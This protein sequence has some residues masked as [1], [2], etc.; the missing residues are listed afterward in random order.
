[1]IPARADLAALDPGRR[2]LLRR[3]LEERGIDPASLPIPPRP[4]PAAPAPL[5]H[6][7]ERLW[8]L[9]RLEPGSA[10]VEC[11]AADLDGDLGADEPGAL[12]PAAL[13]AA[14]AALA[15]RHEA[16]RTVFEESVFEEAVSEETGAG[17][18]QRVLPPPP[19]RLPLADLSALPPPA[20]AAEAAR[21]EAAE[22]RRPFDLERGP[23]MRAHL[24]RLGGGRH[25]LLLGFH[26]IVCDARALSL[27]AGELGELYAAARDRRPARLAPPPLQYADYAVWQREWLGDAWFERRLETRRRGLAGAPTVLDLPADRP[28]SADRRGRGA[29]LRWRLP[30]AV[31]GRAAALA[32]DAG[33]TPFMVLLAALAVVLGRAAGQRDLLI[34]TP[35]A[36]RPRPE[37]EGVVGF[38]VNTLVLRA[39]LG[40]DPAFS[41]LLRRV[42][43]S[44]LE[45]FD[46]QD[47]PF[48]GLVD[49][50][51]AD[52]LPGV[53]PLVQAVLMLQRRS[54]GAGA[55]APGRP[56]LPL[57]R[58]AG[59]AAK[60]DLTVVADE[61]AGEA[62]PE[63]GGEIEYDAGLF[64]AATV[65]RLA[66]GL[67]ALL[68]A[69]GEAPSL[70]LSRLPSLAAAERRC[71]LA[72]WA[73]ASVSRRRGASLEGL[74]EARAAADPEAPALIAAGGAT[75]GAAWSY[76]RL[77]RRARRLA[78]ALR[79]LGVGPERTVGLLMERSPAAVAA[80][81]A[82]LEAEGAYL[83]LDPAYPP[84]RLAQMIEDARPA[85]LLADPGL[86]PRLARAGCP[87]LALG[88][89]FEEVAAESAEPLPRSAAGAGR[90]AYVIFTSG[91][92]GRPKGVMVGHRPAVN[93]TL[94]L[95]AAWSLGPGER[96][97]AVPSLSFDA[98]VGNLFPALASGA[99]LV[100][101]PDPG[102]LS[103][104]DLA[105]LCAATGTTVVDL[106][107]ALWHGWLAGIEA[108]APAPPPSLRLVV[109]GGESLGVEQ[110]AAWHRA[111][112][113]RIGLFGP[114]GPTE[115]TVATTG[116]AAAP[117]WR[118]PA[119][120]GR[121][122]I[123]RP[124]ANARVYLFDPLE[125]FGALAPAGARGEVVIGGAGVARGYLGRPAETADRFRPD[126]F[127]ESPGG[128]LYTT[129]DLARWLP[130]GD[131]LFLGRRDHQV[132]V[133]GFRIEL[134]EIESA[135][136]AHPEV[137][138]CAVLAR[139]RAGAPARLVAYAA[140]RPGRAPSAE[141][142]R[143]WLEERLPPF[144]V[145]AA[146][147]LLERLPVTAGGKV[148]RAALPE[149][150]AVARTAHRAPR[151][152]EEHLLARLWE[153]AL[154]SGPV[155]IDDNFFELGGDS[156]L[157]IQIVAR[158][159]R[160]GLRLTPRQVFRH[161][162]VAALAAAAERFA[163]PGGPAG[164]PA[165]EA[166]GEAA[167]ELPPTPIQRW[168]FDAVRERPEHWNQALLLRIGDRRRLADWGRAVLSVCSRHAALRL[169]AR[170]EGGG[171]RLAVAA[172]G[173][174][175]SFTRADLGALPPARRSPALEAAA[176][177]VQASLDLAAGPIAR[178]VVFDLGADEAPRL[179]WVIHH[180]A[181]D[182]VSWRILLEEAESA[183][184]ALGAGREP[185]ALPP[186]TSFR[187]WARLLAERA[188][189]PEV[190]AERA[191]WT[192]QRTATAMPSDH[193]LGP[194]TVSSAAEVKS[195]LDAE[196]TRRL[197]TEA[198]AGGRT[199]VPEVLLAALLVAWER[200]SGARSVLVDLEGHGRESELFPGVDLS[201]TV[202]WFTVAY[203]LL[204]ELGPARGPASGPA[205]ALGAVKERLRAVPGR[206]LGWGLL[207]RGGGAAAPADPGAAVAFNYLGRF[208]AGGGLFAP[209][210]EDP[211]PERS[212]RGLRS[213]PIEVNASVAG[214]RLRVAWTYGRNRHRRE[215]IERLAAAFD[216]ALA[217][218]IEHCA[219]PGAAAWTPSDFTRARVSQSDLDRLAAR[220][221]GTRA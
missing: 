131:L 180:L 90:L 193:D 54:A 3:V 27:L 129:G 182:G 14:L 206:G 174:G 188:A 67:A 208:D 56:R 170:R 169:R 200:W 107:A 93:L 99:A 83:P 118:P 114:Y 76:G 47:V 217:E 201:R 219:R 119:G 12:D 181:V 58:L 163:T 57:R 199:E 132:K 113:G 40:G 65:E 190:E 209:A 71:L 214:D 100:L 29:L 165:G 187:R 215:S 161:P 152:P 39:D 86:A 98:S 19:P 164:D 104:A 110:V 95:A 198:P 102:T 25:R 171:W 106:P 13:A 87:V 96:L 134:G 204:L 69:A 121:L 80:I 158:A 6:V 111:T 116:F 42:R 18:R 51:A 177:A 105:E 186:T 43:A 74:I 73:G 211:G 175:P 36:N 97:L 75:R 41:E 128:R 155:G 9:D 141:T 2:R 166:P 66:A 173:P 108:G 137:G 146:W 218:L 82:V 191:F 176:R 50:L 53:P 133:R 122:P 22:A 220:L 172:E 124:L 8:V 203:P 52:R 210:P 112:G 79:R 221:A 127:G 24:A 139:E 49:A 143:R 159:A 92:S 138:A 147:V 5:S 135:L 37:L 185:E 156:I 55:S 103:A 184:R 70:P 11:Y 20:A 157:S 89:D 31:A 150:D 149:P 32:R 16:L 84:A 125:P 46:L 44:T 101:H 123:G 38:F 4:D 64:D 178:A 23:P 62:G 196:R 59:G 68:E 212:R 160:E 142:L 7:Q 130:G 1:M 10:Y 15:R 115:A 78:R 168:F 148:D 120:L 30:P 21:L 213:H 197:L 81:L 189:A 48:A 153:E 17:A 162:T 85:V 195:A 45:A 205:A 63:I 126:P 109:A 207:R 192:T 216:A 117:G 202:G 35:A 26:H 72:E 91:S 136:A 167:G 144:A 183:W 151:T 94:E 154:K 60:F 33:A 145:P 88:P 140:P 77:V 61:A 179:L 28:R 194:D 34:G